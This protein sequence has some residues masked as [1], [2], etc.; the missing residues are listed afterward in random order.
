MSDHH[1]LISKEVKGDRTFAHIKELSLE[2]KINQVA[3]LISGG[4][5]TAYGGQYGAGIGSGDGGSCGD[6]T[7]T[8]DIVY[9]IAT[10]GED[11][12]SIGRGRNGSCGKIWFDTVKVYDGSIWIFSLG[13]GISYGDLYFFKNGD[14]TWLLK[15]P[16]HDN[17]EDPPFIIG[18]I[19]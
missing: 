9:V 12:E 18:P 14:D 6:I 7:I 1:I 5:V 8:K 4:T 16:I 10:R 15:P 19:G 2:E 17:D 3:Y 11:A 13:S